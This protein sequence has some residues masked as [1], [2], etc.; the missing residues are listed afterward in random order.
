MPGLNKMRSEPFAQMKIKTVKDLVGIGLI[1]QISNRT[2]SRLFI[3]PKQGLETESCPS[4][5]VDNRL[6]G[7]I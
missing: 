4:M 5:N 3:T 7:V 6:K 2:E 1:K